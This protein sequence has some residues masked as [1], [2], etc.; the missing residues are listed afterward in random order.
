[1]VVSPAAT[2]FK[3]PAHVFGKSF[4][5]GWEGNVNVGFSFTS[6]NSNYSTMSTGLRVQKAG[7]QDNLSVYVRSLWNKNRNSGGHHVTTQNA[8]WGGAR[9]DRNLTEKT[10]GFVSYDFERDRPKNL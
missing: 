5:E 8:F 2:A 1:P 7:T 10:F 3:R 4:L 9:Y 6:G